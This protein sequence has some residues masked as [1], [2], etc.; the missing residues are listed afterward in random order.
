MKEVKEMEIAQRAVEIIKQGAFLVVQAKGRKNVMTIGWA[1]F[2]FMWRKSVMMVA[3]RNSRFTHG[4][5]EQADSFT[6][7][8]PSGN[9]QKEI[10]FCGSKS[11]KD[12]DKFKECQLATTKAQKV[13]TPV[14]RI[15]G[16][17]Y[18]CKMMYKTP[19]DPKFMDKDMED[20]YPQKDYHTLYFGEIVACYISE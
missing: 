7:S 3:V 1:T 5:I 15:P 14:L 16:Y 19:M 20:L 8:V 4:I 11:G 18:E 9:M 13:S 6:V 10:N 17:H 12:L 2:G